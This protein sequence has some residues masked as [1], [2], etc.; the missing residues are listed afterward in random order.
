MLRKSDLKIVME[1][2]FL[3]I[4]SNYDGYIINGFRF[5]AE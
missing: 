2:I 5:Y 4:G 3:S 1:I